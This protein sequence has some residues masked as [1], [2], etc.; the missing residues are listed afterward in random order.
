MRRWGEHPRRAVLGEGHARHRGRPDHPRRPPLRGAGAEG[1]CAWWSRRLHAAGAILV[2]K[3]TTPEFAHKGVTDSAL[4]GVTR[5]PWALG[6]THA[7][8]PAAA[9][10]WRRP[11][12]WGRSTIGTDEGGSIRIPASYCGVVG[13]KPTFGLVP[14]VPVGCRGAAHAPAAALARTDRGRRP[15]PLGHRRAATTATAGPCPVDP[16][17]YTRDARASRRHARRVAWS[18]RLG[19][20]AVDP[21]VLRVTGGRRATSSAALGWAVE[22]ADPGFADPAE[23]ADAFR[24]PG[25]RRRRSAMA[26]SSGTRE[27]HGPE[28]SSRWSRPA[29]G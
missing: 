23:V 22:D 19:Y 10:R 21:E 28:L 2:G 17:D 7:A 3:T 6:R 13:L 1:G 27:A 16:A 24:Y 29:G 8:G 25:S 14:R 18:P 26:P 5:N 20:A 9:R 15:V 11:P 4:F 12:A